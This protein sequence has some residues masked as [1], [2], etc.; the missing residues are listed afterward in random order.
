M[1]TN[2]AVM[3]AAPRMVTHCDK[4]ARPGYNTRKAHE[5]IDEPDVLLAKVW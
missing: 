4:D 2:T 3:W 5:Y 1:T